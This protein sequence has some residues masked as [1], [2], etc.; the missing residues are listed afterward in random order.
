MKRRILLAVTLAMV[1]PTAWCADLDADSLIRRLA[2]PAP[3][4]IAFKEVRYSSL[5][6]EP[7]IV[8]GELGYA[9]PTELERKVLAPYRE[10]TTISGDSVRVERDAEQ[11]RTFALKRAPELR[12]LLAGFSALLAGDIPTLRRNFTVQLSGSENSWNLEL[13]PVD[14]SAQRRVNRILVNGRADTPKCFSTLNRD[15]GAS[16]ML[17]G[18]AANAD[19]PKAATLD[20]LLTLCRAE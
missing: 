17:L 2:R 7:L 4:S 6:R 11:P 16:V 15:G 18:P 9:G 5:L 12:G 1:L 19:V 13:T 10:I 14:T 8:S 3:A 20:R